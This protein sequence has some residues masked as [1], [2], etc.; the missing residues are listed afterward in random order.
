MP[1]IGASRSIHFPPPT[2]PPLSDCR[3]SKAAVKD[4]RQ[5]LAQGRPRT[6]ASRRKRDFATQINV[7]ECFSGALR[8]TELAREK[9]R[10]L[11]NS[12]SRHGDLQVAL[13]AA[14]RLEASLSKLIEAEEST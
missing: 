9:L 5:S 1:Q 6:T 12:G 4:G 10:E 14:R 13:S 8:D 3:P 7:M 11:V 2:D